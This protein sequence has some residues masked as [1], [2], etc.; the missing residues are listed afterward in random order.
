MHSCFSA[1]SSL[2]I[3]EYGFPWL[4]FYFLPKAYVKFKVPP[5]P[6][7]LHVF[8]VNQLPQC[9]LSCYYTSDRFSPQ[10]LSVNLFTLMNLFIL[11]KKYIAANI[12]APVGFTW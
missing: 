7:D 4:P 12:F 6:I 3:I 10:K 11:N 9:T 2:K 1:S 8:F 5:L